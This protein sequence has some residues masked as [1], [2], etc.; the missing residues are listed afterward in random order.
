MLD[1]SLELKGESGSDQGL[2]LASCLRRQ[3]RVLRTD[4]AHPFGLVLILFR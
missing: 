3:V 4:H 2:N 1:I